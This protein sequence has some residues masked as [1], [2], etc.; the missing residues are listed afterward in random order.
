MGELGFSCDVVVEVGGVRRTGWNGET[1]NL[2]SG[3]GGTGGEVVRI[4]KGDDR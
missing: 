1:G 3:S 4:R 2:G